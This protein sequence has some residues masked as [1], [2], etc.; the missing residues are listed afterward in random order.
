M[1]RESAIPRLF[2]LVAEMA[3]R[4]DAL[5]PALGAAAQLLTCAFSEALEIERR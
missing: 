5:P 2:L 1:V 4:R 3:W